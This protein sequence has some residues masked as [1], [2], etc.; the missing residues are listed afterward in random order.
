MLQKFTIQTTSLLA[1]LVS[2][3]FFAN[4]LNAQT[5]IYE[6]QFAG[7]IDSTWQ[8]NPLTCGEIDSLHNTLWE[9]S[10]DGRGEMGAY[11]GDG[12]T[13][14]SPSVS[15]G[16]ALF[17]SDFLDNNGTAGNFY[18]GL[19][20]APHS[21]ELVSPII[22]CSAYPNVS[23]QFYQSYRAFQS[24]TRVEVSADSGA[25]WNP[26]VINDEISGNAST[27]PG[28]VKLIEISDIAGGSNG[29]Q[30]KFIFDGRYYFW[31]VDDVRLIVTPNNNLEMPRAALSV[32]YGTPVTQRVQMEIDA[33][34]CNQFA[35]TEQPN[36]TLNCVITD[37]PG[38]VLY[39]ESVVR[40][41][42]FGVV[43]PFPIDSCEGVVIPVLFDMEGL[44]L[45][46]GLYNM[47]YTVNSDSMNFTNNNVYTH[48]FQVTPNIIRK[49]RFDSNGGLTVSGGGEYEFGY[50]FF[51]PNDGDQAMAANFM[52]AA[53][54]GNTMEGESATVKIYEIGTEPLDEQTADD[55]I[56]LGFGTYE[57]AASYDNY[58]T[59]TVDLFNLDDGEQGIVLEGGKYYLV[60]LSYAGSNTVFTSINS[61]IDF[62]Y[63]NAIHDVIIDGS[64][65]LFSGGFT[66]ADR[67]P[68]IDVFIAPVPDPNSS[69]E[70]VTSFKT[71]LFPNPADQQV[72][73]ALELE[74][75]AKNMNIRITDAFGK[76]IEDRN[77]QNIQ[78]ETLTFDTKN[79]AP[80][81]YLMFLR[82]DDKVQS[83]K[84]M[85]V[86]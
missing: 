70:V 29:V 82:S 41:D 48:E 43:E 30:F 54:S 24:E 74:A 21:A 46:L 57:F 8:N 35:L 13:I 20:P 36:T 33:E 77:Y 39:D 83:Q 73:L 3:C 45:D 5:I 2:F 62:Q 84:F 49:T 17:S 76:V 28:D 86:H 80:G 85:I 18:M 9:W 67:I 34:V 68:A 32:L 26:Y 66:G 42:T 19:S 55:L 10:D 51:T 71:K 37:E 27:D 4:N 16:C 79:Y 61:S 64:G 14:Q 78:N 22:D 53:Q 65:E 69:E 81:T 59:A 15:N 6:E 63:T 40:T 31:L 12:G 11:W 56:I 38:N 23:L 47:T 25:T 58:D 60:M 44:D 52:M 75:V 7:G 1:I 50:Q 72:Q